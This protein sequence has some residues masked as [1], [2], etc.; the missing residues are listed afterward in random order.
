MKQTRE[1][2]TGH[3]ASTNGTTAD[4]HGAATGKNWLGLDDIAADLGVSLSTITK[5]SARRWPYFPHCVRLPS[6]RI[7]VKREWYEEWLTTLEV[8]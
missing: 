2:T 1:F 8:A 7:K 5:W 3:G 6:G 4:G